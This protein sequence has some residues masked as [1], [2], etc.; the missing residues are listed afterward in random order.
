MLS[1]TKFNKNYTRIEYWYYQLM[2]SR[3]IDLYQNI[4]MLQM[5]FNKSIEI[6]KYTEI[7]NIQNTYHYYDNLAGLKEMS[8]D[9]PE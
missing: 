1:I 8:I 2:M 5:C 7:F 4:K 6:Y 9:L 3:M